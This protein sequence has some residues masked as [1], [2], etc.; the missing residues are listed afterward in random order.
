MLGTYVLSSGYYD[1]YYSQAQAVRSK[2]TKELEDI[3]ETVD[4]I[5]TPTTPTGAFRV[6]EKSDPLSMYAA[7][8]F[9]VPANIAGMPA[10]SVPAGKDENDMPLGL[11]FVAP[12]FHED[13]LFMAGKDFEAGV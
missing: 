10:I 13:W 5:V 6:G 7:D 9:T 3:F 11:Q 2:I 8:T 12:H 4:L 1:A